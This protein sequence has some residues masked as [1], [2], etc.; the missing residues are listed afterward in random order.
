MIVPD[1]IVVVVVVVVWWCR[2]SWRLCLETLVVDQLLGWWSVIT[3][4]F[5]ATQRQ[6]AGVRRQCLRHG[7]RTVASGNLRMEGKISITIQNQPLN[8]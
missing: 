6:V 8:Q 1:G 7:G 2:V 4:N 3:L 5:K